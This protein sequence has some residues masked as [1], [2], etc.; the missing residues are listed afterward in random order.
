MQAAGLWLAQGRP[1]E[2]FALLQSA[3]GS[4]REDDT[5]FWR[6]VGEVAVG[7]QDTSAARSAFERLAG[8][9]DARPEDFDML[10]D[11]LQPAGR[12]EAARAAER[13]WRR[14]GLERHLML[15]LNLWAAERRWQDVRRLLAGLDA[16]QT[17]AAEAQPDFLRLRAELWM[18]SGQPGRAR[19]D[20]ERALRLDPAS[21]PTREA[22]IWLVIDSQDPL[23]LRT[24]LA[25]HEDAWR[26]ERRLWGALAAAHQ[27]L[28]QVQI[29][30]DRYLTPALPEHREDFLW[31]MNYADALEQ[32]S[33]P[34]RAWRLR[35]HLWRQS[36]RKGFVAGDPQLAEAKEVARARL[37][38]SQSPGDPELALL[39][40]LL[41]ADRDAST[42][43]AVQELVLAW[44]QN[45][46]EYLAVRGYLWERYAR[47]LS[48]PLWAEITAALQLD[49]RI[50]VGELLDRYGE[51]LPRYDRVNAARRVGD[52]RLAQTLA[53][54]SQTVQPQDDETHLQLT[55]ALLDYSHWG[56]LRLTARRLGVLDE[57]E[58]AA[59]ARIAAAPDL[60]L[61]LDAGRIGRSLRDAQAFGSAPDESFLQALLRWDHRDQGQTRLGLGARDSE[62]RYYP[63][64][65]E[66][67]QPVDRRLTALL[68]AGSDLPATESLGVRVAGMK[69]QVLAGFRY[70]ASRLDRVLVQWSGERYSTQ[71]HHPLGTG[72]RLDLSYAY[73]LRL[74]PRDLELSAFF[75]DFRF[76]RKL[77]TSPE[78]LRAYAPLVPPALRELLAGIENGTLPPGE[79]VQ[80][81]LD[82]FTA[83]AGSVLPTSARY[84]GLR[85]STDTR[86]QTDY[87][88]G[89]RPF[90]SAALTNNSELGLGYDFLLGIAG[91]VFGAD[92]LQA[93][94]YVEKGGSTSF[95]T[96][97]VMSLTYRLHF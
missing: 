4:A 9:A 2:A 43:P 91:A 42:S 40:E 54:D 33:E 5:E 72:N 8:G 85:A 19:R 31:L 77:G 67:D 73:A 38:L 18:Q 74:E 23:A 41:R 30:L 16:G 24:L 60:A 58:T 68:A 14:F 6:M 89:W 71:D 92:H 83:S 63:V 61:H 29:A 64:L 87:T 66:H 59:T 82:Q 27:A 55:E 47:S 81:A 96:T 90:A 48:R 56:G 62:H 84:Y 44:F 17:A 86:F 75:T 52:V 26:R 80:S 50:A 36:W 20:L 11:L 78:D 51:R 7:L 25:G 69:D 46:G 21:N 53:F 39:R 95:P 10:I 22:L 65:I 76:R 57:F 32:N 3:Q 79:T 1:A 12:D 28:G 94:V 70:Q 35:E 97:R 34:D 49:D 45:Q 93:S 37:A 88:R 15:A 13:A